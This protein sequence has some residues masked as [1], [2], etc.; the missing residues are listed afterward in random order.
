MVLICP[1]SLIIKTPLTRYA[2]ICIDILNM[3]NTINDNIKANLKL[4]FHNHKF[5]ESQLALAPTTPD[6]LP[7]IAAHLKP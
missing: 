7:T 3:N 6:L 5:H 4:E 2:P 1:S